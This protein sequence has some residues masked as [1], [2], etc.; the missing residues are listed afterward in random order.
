MDAAGQAYITG[1]T[2]SADFPASR[3]PGYDTSHNGYDDAFVVKL[4][5]AGT[6]LLY[7]TFLDGSNNANGNDIAVDGAGQAYITGYTDSPDFPASLGP[8]YDTSFNGGEYDAFVVKLNPAGTALL[9]AT[10]LGGSSSD[11]G[12]GIAV[13]GAGQAYVTGRT[14]SA[15]F[16]ASLGPGYDTSYN[17]VRTPSLSS[18]LRPAP[19]CATP[20]SSAAAM[21]TM[22]T[23]SLWTAPARPTLRA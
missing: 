9:Y 13:D 19:A 11:F 14:N 20:P 12:W 15:D 4:N 21:M 10:F 6:A 23:A 8:G 1:D 5:T 22:A 3:G 17:G 2:Q 16:P 18:W 7:A